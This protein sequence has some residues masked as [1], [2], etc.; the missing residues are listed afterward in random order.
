MKKKCIKALIAVWF[1]LCLCFGFAACE[2]G[3]T[4]KGLSF[5]TLVQKDGA[6]YTEVSEETES[7]S[8]LGEVTG[9]DFVVTTDEEGLHPVGKTVTLEEGEN[10]FFV[11]ENGKG[12]PYKVVVYRKE[13]AVQVT[14]SFQ[15]LVEEDGKY[16]AEVGA[17]QE[18]FDFSSE[19]S[20]GAFTV[21]ADGEKTQEVDKSAAP[22]E[23]GENA[24]YLFAEGNSK[25]YEVVVYRKKTVEVSVTASGNAS[26]TGGGSYEEGGE[27][28]VETTCENERYQFVGWKIGE[29]IVS[30]KQREIFTAEEGLELSAVWEVRWVVAVTV[31]LDVSGSMGKAGLELQVNGAKA[32]LNEL[33]ADDYFCVL[34]M[35]Y[36]VQTAYEMGKVGDKSK[37]L[38]ALDKI[39]FLDG[40]TVFAPAVERAGQLLS[41]VKADVR[42]AVL[43]TD[44]Q[45]AD[46]EEYL[47]F[48]DA[49]AKRGV[50]LSVF[51][52]NVADS[53]T[54]SALGTLAEIGEGYCYLVNTE[55]DVVV[56][57]HS[58]ISRLIEEQ[59]LEEG[60][61]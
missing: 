59:Y 40:G 3:E 31:I 45:P 12:E 19:V 43:F 36:Q 22:L 55:K 47:A 20:G 15:T 10:Y 34:L 58:E 52:L 41:A 21:Y 13:K 30:S 6:Y 24:F 9:A 27:V 37:A 8:F 4:P 2:K 61:E 28:T 42:R 5:Q 11:F 7:F 35:N 48:V 23:E 32:I 53:I 29:E 54:A 51:G 50:T 46:K 16:R 26:C 57:V 1:G 38:A 56:A 17:S 60:N 49:N 25:P 18:V 14:L 33:C 39:S 44:G